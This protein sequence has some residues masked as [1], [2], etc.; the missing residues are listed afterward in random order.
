MEESCSVYSE[1]GMGKGRDETVPRVFPKI[2]C[3][4]HTSVPVPFTKNTKTAGTDR[5]CWTVLGYLVPN[6]RDFLSRRILVQGLPCRFL[7]GSRLSRGFETGIRNGTSAHS[8]SEFDYVAKFGSYLIRN[9]S[10]FSKIY[11]K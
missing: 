8:L 5:D 3:V 6:C 2:P 1:P 7:S 10:L 9:N 11:I 4:P